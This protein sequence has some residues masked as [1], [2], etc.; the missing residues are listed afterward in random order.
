MFEP[1]NGIIA[2]M[3]RHLNIMMTSDEN[4]MMM[5]DASLN[6]GVNPD[7]IA[8]GSAKK[9]N[10]RCIHDN[11]HVFS[12]SP[13]N[14]VN[15]G[16]RCPAC[17]GNICIT[18]VNDIAT[19]HPRL[20]RLFDSN[21]NNVKPSMITS[22]GRAAAI[23]D[24]H[25][26]KINPSWIC[27]NGHS[28][29]RALKDMVSLD[30]SGKLMDFD[31]CQYC[32][33]RKVLPVFNDVATMHLELVHYWSPAN[34]LEPT[35]VTSGS[36]EHI[37]LRCPKD[38]H[39]WTMTVNRACIKGFTCADCAGKVL[40]S[41]V[42]DVATLCPWLVKQWSPSNDKSPSE[43]RA[44]DSTYVADW[45]CDECG[46]EWRVKVSSRCYFNS[47]C[48]ACSVF[49]ATAN[50]NNSLEAKR[51]DIARFFDPELNNG[52][53]ADEIRAGSSRIFNWRCPNYPDHVFTMSVYARCKMKGDCVYCSNDRVLIGFNDLATTHPGLCL[54]WSP[55]NTLNPTDVVAGSDITVKWS[56][57]VCG[58]DWETPVYKRATA[59]RGCPNCAR[60][61]LNSGSSN[62]E[63]EIHDFMQSLR[64][65]IDFIPNDRKVLNGRELDVYA[66]D[67]HIALEFNGLKWHS[68]DALQS[69]TSDAF[70]YHQFKT[71]DCLDAG[72]MLTML[73]EPDWLFHREITMDWLRRWLDVPAANAMDASCL[74]V[75]SLNA[76]DDGWNDAVSWLSGNSIHQRIGSRTVMLIDDDSCIHACMMLD[77]NVIIGYAERLDENV[78]NGFNMLASYAGAVSMRSMLPPLSCMHVDSV[79]LDGSPV[80]YEVHGK[81]LE[82]VDCIDGRDSVNIIIGSGDYMF[83]L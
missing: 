22:H 62:F 44:N 8:A 70:N 64:P 45:I 35:D 7:S 82:R 20:A 12:M 19:E 38:G 3:A 83:R 57:H 25:G 47:G 26:R 42:N 55:L 2:Y 21:A 13:S 32:S 80:A 6:P 11:R 73:Y 36:N 10:W 50:K 60:I 58:W 78:N 59:G 39:E 34:K 56:C 66:P 29:K 33:G 9:L 46:C 48:P 24:E 17:L 14:L 65:D 16:Y 27:R 37:V 68:L 5:F 15:Q 31:G 67:L 54:D 75:K 74:H 51:P 79:A 71:R 43:V 30:D 23:R 28:F 18:G 1:M 76:G 69:R 4:L 77:G 81:S 63:R 61:L 41:G 72:I 49:N 40:H 52:V 53:T